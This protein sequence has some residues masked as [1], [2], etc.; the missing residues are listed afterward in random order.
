VNV[1]LKIPNVHVKI[2][3]FV[4]LIVDA[5]QPVFKNLWV[6]IARKCKNNVTKIQIVFVK[7]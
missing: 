1:T 3:K 6:V 4:K 5:H 7:N 2:E